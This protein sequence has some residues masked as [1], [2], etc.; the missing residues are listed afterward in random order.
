MVTVTKNFEILQPDDWH[1]HFR[2]G[3]MLHMVTN[4]SSRI[5]NR[6]IAMPNTIEPITNT[7][8]AKSYKRKIEQASKY[9]FN[10]LIP[11]YL[12]EN[13]DSNDFR[14]GL[15][16]GIFFGAKLYP[17]NATTNS[18]KGI[19]D[20]SKIYNLFEILEEENS[21][22]LIHGEKVSENI[23]IFDREQTFIDEE[24][25]KIRNTFQNL[26]IVL[27]HV[28]TAYGVN[29]IKENKNIAGTITP[30][31][32]LLTKKDVFFDDKI[33][34]HHYCMPVVKNETDLIELRNAASQNNNKFFLG[35]DSAPHHTRDKTYDLSSK[36]G[37]FSAP[38]SIELYA[39]IF[40]Q[41]NALD[42]LETFAS[43]NGPI[44]YGLPINS[45]KIKLQKKEWIVPEIS[46]YKDIEV[47]NFYAN[48]KI[49]WKVV[50]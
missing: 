30:H 40:E 29:Y 34:P 23:D 14:L 24:L 49:N 44:F 43:I 8:K 5:N 48:K 3:D 28:S 27:E 7:V 45:S 35:T 36:P 4:Y 12:T 33:N 6:C 21:P 2:E 32:M 42:K 20:L 13:L 17:T 15:Q 26:K 46:R 10:P 25:K 37:I 19:T 9:N 47:K 16:N 39:E 1:V 18:K 38:C 50:N 11:C 41:E 22:L 31:H